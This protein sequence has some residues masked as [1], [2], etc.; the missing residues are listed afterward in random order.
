MQL[1]KITENWYKI[2]TKTGEW[3]IENGLITPTL[4][5]KRGPLSK[6]FAAEIE[7]LYAVHG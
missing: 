7:K 6:H 2:E 3:T 4:K 1:K 5:L